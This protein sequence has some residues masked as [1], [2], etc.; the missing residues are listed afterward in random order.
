MLFLGMSIAGFF[1]MD[2]GLRNGSKGEILT[3]SNTGEHFLLLSSFVVPF[4]G[5]LYGADRCWL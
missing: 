4:S 1:K 5:F 2:T 3:T